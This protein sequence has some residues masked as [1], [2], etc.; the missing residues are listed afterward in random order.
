MAST[1]RSEVDSRRA[2]ELESVDRHRSL[3]WRTLLTLILTFLAPFLLLTVYFHFQSLAVKD[4]ADRNRLMLVA[5]YQAHMLDLFIRERAVNL[6]NLIDDP[7][8]EI[9]PSR[10][11][12]QTYLDVLKQDSDSFVDLGFFDVDGIQVAYEGPFPVLERRDYKQE[13][14]FQNV[15]SS[16]GDF[17]MTDIY[18]GMRQ[19]P[20]FTIAVSRVRSGQ[21]IA[22]RATLD[23]EKIYD[24]TSGLEG[25]RGLHSSIVNQ[26]GLYQVVTPSLGSP[27]AE[28]LVVPS[29]TPARGSG[30]IDTGSKKVNYGY[31]WL[32]EANWAVITQ[33]PSPEP[34]RYVLGGDMRIAAGALAVI[35]LILIAT[36]VS[37]RKQVQVMEERDQTKAQLEH[38]AKLASVGELA[39][40]IAHEINNPLAIISEEAGLMQDLMNPE[41]GRQVTPEELSKKLSNIQTAVFRCRDITRKLL[42]FVRR[43][44]FKLTRQ[45]I[46][47]LVN[48]V[49]DGFFAREMALSNITIKREYAPGLPEIETDRSQLQQVVLN[50]VKNAADAIESAGTITI[51]IKVRDDRLRIS[52]T[53]TGKGMSPRQLEKV[54]MP[55]FTTKDVGKGTGLGLSVSYGIAQG[56]GG[57]I[58]VRSKQGTGSTFTIVL[59]L[60]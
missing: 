38:S 53:D 3:M 5:E 60:N 29:L 9:N 24:F 25:A 42:G 45:S 27:L 55:F 43:S 23:P 10:S 35:L 39:A 26:D 16:R 58:E 51:S 40:G 18:L 48:E 7:H 37:A 31:A 50:L 36:Y 19:R 32:T 12:L 22:I 46:P 2:V 21:F 57:D 11:D 56:L 49:V 34:S 33:D 54:F 15:R 30:E 52:I 1:D 41:F 20:H 44:E 17:V 6:A 8:L 59:P 28:S 14:W 4:T 47:G 13:A